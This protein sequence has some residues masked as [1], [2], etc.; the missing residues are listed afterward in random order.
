[1]ESGSSSGYTCAGLI[2]F[3][4][5]HGWWTDGCHVVMCNDPASHT[6]CGNGD[7]LLRSRAVWRR[8]AHLL[9]KTS[10]IGM[11][12]DGVQRELVS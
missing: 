6:W 12:A 8:V 5:G 10:A 7:P 9:P 4:P 3:G 11:L 2:A 1:M